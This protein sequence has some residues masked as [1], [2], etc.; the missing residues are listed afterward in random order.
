MQLKCS[1]WRKEVI[2]WKCFQKSPYTN[3]N[4]ANKPWGRSTNVIRD[5]QF[6]EIMKDDVRITIPA[7]LVNSGIFFLVFHISS[8]RFDGHGMKRIPKE[9]TRVEY[10]KS[11]GKEPKERC[12]PLLHKLLYIIRL[13]A[14][15]K[16]NCFHTGNIRHLLTLAL[17]SVEH[18]KVFR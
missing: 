9:G 15:V 1:L 10:S 4:I 13:Y 11:D 6:I 5:D 12:R 17:L 16:N 18:Y 2:M 7:L 8:L 3:D 14:N